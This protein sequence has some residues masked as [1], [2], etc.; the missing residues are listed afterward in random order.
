MIFRY[1]TIDVV[2]L[3]FFLSSGSVK[4]IFLWER[5][6]TIKT[7]NFS[8]WFWSWSRPTS[9]H[10][11]LFALW[12]VEI[13]L[14]F[15][16]CHNSVEKTFSLWQANFYK[17]FFVFQCVFPSSHM[18]PIF[19]P[20]WSFPM[21]VNVW[22]WWILTHLMLLTIVLRCELT[23]HQIKLANLDVQKFPADQDVLYYFTLKSLLVK[24]LKHHTQVFWIRVYSLYVSTNNQ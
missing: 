5:F 24:C 4:F 11:C 23:F 9:I 14:L 19:L 12:D 21:L 18:E 6:T 10:V 17:W 2:L 13:Y 22:K 8:N 20:L 3:F 15:N 16:K 7:V 1:L